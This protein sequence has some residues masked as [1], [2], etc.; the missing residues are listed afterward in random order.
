MVLDSCGPTGSPGVVLATRLGLEVADSGGTL[1]MKH[2]L[3]C[4]VG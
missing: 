2:E 4:L 3:S 1:A